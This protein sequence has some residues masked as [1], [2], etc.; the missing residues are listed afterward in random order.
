MKK[1]I[2]L[3]KQFLRE[4]DFYVREVIGDDNITYNIWCAL[5][6][7]DGWNEMDLI[8]IAEDEELWLD[9]VNAFKKCCEKGG[10]I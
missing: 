3:R 1:I 8:D 9:C 5:G 10:V 2:E 4:F 7:P 6:L